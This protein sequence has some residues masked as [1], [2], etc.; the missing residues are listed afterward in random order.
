MEG[1][2]VLRYNRG[3]RYEGTFL[4]GYFYGEGRFNYTDGGY[5]SG[6]FKH[7]R[8]NPY[9][10]VSFPDPNGLKHGFGMRV[11]ANGSKYQV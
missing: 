1:K 9:S 11:F 8:L 4:K 2:G 6:E 10:G 5:Y 3:D 7:D